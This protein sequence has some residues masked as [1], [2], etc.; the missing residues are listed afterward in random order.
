MVVNA[1]NDIKQYVEQFVIVQ[2]WLVCNQNLAFL[3]NFLVKI[4]IRANVATVRILNSDL[5]MF[6]YVPAVFLDLIYVDVMVSSPICPSAHIS[7]PFKPG[8]SG[9][10]AQHAKMISK[11]TY[12]LP[13]RARLHSFRD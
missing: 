10:A 1:T 6:Y 8:P 3:C 12:A 4:A 9:K 2:S 13:T 11:K 5:Q 7:T